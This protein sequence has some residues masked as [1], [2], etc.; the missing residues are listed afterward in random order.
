LKKK[1]TRLS[2]QISRILL[3]QSGLDLAGIHWV[4]VGGESAMERGIVHR[5]LVSCPSGS[6]EAV[7]SRSVQRV[8]ADEP[9]NREEEIERSLLSVEK[10]V[11]TP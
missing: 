10:G 6:R 4:I 3:T 7:D 8:D 2:T 9:G 11:E 1:G 5:V